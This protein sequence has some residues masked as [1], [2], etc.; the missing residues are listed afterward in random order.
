MLI[1]CNSSLNNSLIWNFLR[2]IQEWYKSLKSFQTYETT[3]TTTRKQL[4]SYGWFRRRS[5]GKAISDEF[6]TKKIVGSISSEKKILS[7]FR[8]VFWQTSDKILIKI[9][10][11]KFQRK[12]LDKIPKDKFSK[13]FRWTHFQKKSDRY[14]LDEILTDILWYL[15]EIL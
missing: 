11:T 3:F 12:I 10:S 4:V 2:A 5:V 14:I 13:K 15:S 6:L 8:R 7:E 9:F 1:P